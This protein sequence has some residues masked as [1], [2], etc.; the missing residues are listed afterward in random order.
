MYEHPSRYA[1]LI[2]TAEDTDAEFEAKLVLAE[3]STAA[4]RLRNAGAP[5][6]AIAEKLSVTVRQAH[7]L[8]AGAL[9]S[10]LREPAEN[11][12]A[13]QQAITQDIVRAMYAPMSGG[14]TAAARSILQA[15]DHQAKLFGLYAPTR[16]RVGV[17]DEDF[18]I[19]TARLLREIGASDPGVRELP[20]TVDAETEDDWV[21]G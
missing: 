18:A 19:T 15:L 11:I 21:T 8:I 6:T 1:H 13:N 17:T 14:D 2:P 10:V 16:V 12:I 4:V 7:D 20:G 5:V 3:K 9:R